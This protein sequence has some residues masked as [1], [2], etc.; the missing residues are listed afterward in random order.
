[1]FGV[2]V[3]ERCGSVI[4]VCYFT[5][6]HILNFRD[7]SRGSIFLHVTSSQ[8]HLIIASSSQKQLFDVFAVLL[9]HAHLWQSL[10]FGIR[11]NPRR[12]L[13]PSF[14]YP[15]GIVGIWLSGWIWGVAISCRWNFMERYPP[16]GE[17]RLK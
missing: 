12:A 13:R 7:S 15:F 1:M 16:Y 9:G 17:L 5:A 11:M 14:S 6:K 10:L 4:E 8:P 3:L 2:D